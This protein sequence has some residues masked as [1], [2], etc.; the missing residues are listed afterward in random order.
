MKLLIVYGTTEGQTRKIAEFLKAEADKA[1]IQT[2]ICDATVC[3][4]SPDGYDGVMI[5]ASM[6]MHRY[7]ASIAHYVNTHMAALN[8]MPSA[9]FSVSLSAVSRG[10]DEESYRELEEITTHFLLDTGWKPG[11]VG[12]IAGALR[13]TQYDYFKKF[14]MR[15]IA[16]R[17]KGNT[18]T[19]HDQEYTDWG[20]LRTFLQEFIRQVQT[21][22]TLEEEIG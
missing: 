10:Y 17:G 20:Q 22:V 8:E 21:R 16:K 4:I 12:Q 7:Q 5:G 13:Y 19:S 3:P 2:A 11:M 6:H 18:D 15:Q 1:G 9:F 14:I